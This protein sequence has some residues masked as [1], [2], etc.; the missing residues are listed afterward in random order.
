MNNIPQ[1]V[2]LSWCDA[3]ILNSEHE[4]VLNGIGNLQ[5][6]NP[7]WKITVSTDADID[8]YLHNNLDPSDWQLVKDCAIVA[9]TDIWRLLKIYQ[10]GGVY[11]DV[12]R[13][14]NVQLDTLCLPGIKCVLPTTRDWDFAQDFMMSEPGNPIAK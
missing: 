1:L 12:D 6:L 7:Q 10:E 4:L 3:N 14:C 5:L 13:L 9:K 2:H 8:S 11:M